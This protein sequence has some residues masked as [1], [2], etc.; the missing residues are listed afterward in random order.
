MASDPTRTGAADR[1][2]DT[3]ADRRP[4]DQADDQTVTIAAD[5]TLTQDADA[6]SSIR[7]A[8]LPDQI[9][10]YRVIRLI[11][12]GGMGVVY[13]A[14]QE[15]PRR[16][17]ALKV[18]R[19]GFISPS[20]LRRFE[21]E[22]EVLG[23]LHHP[24]IAQVYEA[25]TADAGAGPQ[26]FFAME[27]VIGRT[28]GTYANAA[29]LTA[30]QRLELLAQ[31]C[32]AVHHAHRKGVIHRDLKPGNIIVDETGQPK[33]LD[34]GVARVTE[35][36]IQATM[37]TDIGQ[38]VGT[39]SYMSP[40]QVSGDPSQLDARS[41][42]YALG[43][44]LYELLADRHPYI[45]Q[46]KALPEAVRVIREEDPERLDAIDR[47]FRGDIATIATKALEKEKSRRYHSAEE[48]GEDIRRWLRDEPIIARPPSTIYHLQ[49]L[50][51]RHRAL[52]GGV[53]AAF[54]V[55]LAGVIVSSWQ[56][57]RAT[58]AEGLATK[59]AAK[60]EAVNTFLQEMLGSADPTQAKGE[61]VRVRD[62]LD[63]AA[64]KIE[65]G[66]L[67]EQPDVEAA[68]RTTL[69]STY[70][71]LGLYDEADPH[72]RS[73][74]EMKR[75]VLG[76]EH[77][78][79]AAALTE[80]AIL[81]RLQGD[82]VA[83]EPL[84]REAV[85]IQRK[86]L[87]DWHPEV[88]ASLNN[89]ANLARARG[90]LASAEGH[91]REALE[92]Q[93]KRYGDE[94]ESVAA[95]LSSMAMLVQER[96]D[97]DGAVALSRESLAIRRKV[98]DPQHPNMAQTLNNLAGQL[99]LQG[100]FD[101]AEASFR[102]AL[103][104]YR[105]VFGDDHPLV[106]LCLQNLG[107]TLLGKKELTQSEAMFREALSIQAA[108]L[109][110]R[111]PEIAGALTNLGR[112]LVEQGRYA[113]AEPLLREGLSIREEK[114]PPKHWSKLNTQSLLGAALAGQGRF[115]EAEPLL[116][117]SYEEM[118]DQ[119]AAPAARKEQALARIVSLYED[120]NKPEKASIWRAKTEPGR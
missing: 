45:V 59:Q 50:A 62:A 51:K 35:S 9:G 86:S 94:H 111:H 68:V 28:L 6:S 60:A 65:D 41:D 48:L 39:L 26:P 49:K 110:A 107:V 66:S 37:Q 53:G 118:K 61:D 100:D 34:F 20:M 42:V 77:H 67:A 43:V 22:A 73:A 87:G 69:G 30:R 24:G 102:E 40:E 114:L 99:Q 64:K 25:G 23:R 76:R 2:R 96:G 1:D 31:I 52:V 47:A 90:D 78:D 92:I 17:V 29:R 84:V 36:D 15:R 8:A 85:E 46:G 33:V 93:R 79:V 63:A 5:R 106:G 95:T 91:L 108:K 12:A 97:L 74:L 58:R 116:L 120:W 11:G 81:R 113:E 70:R 3:D 27:L 112:C 105:E 56:A 14:Q 4:D 54:I 32:D 57:V 10:H 7:V 21:Q 44:I 75:R 98:L 80:L 104:I 72:L 82:Y 55:L 83:A 115:E 71:A 89:L 117:S 13:E 119:A 16:V 88:A 103:S 38:I 101:A 109:P 18:I 19:P